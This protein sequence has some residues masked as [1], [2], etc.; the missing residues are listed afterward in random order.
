MEL[1]DDGD[2]ICLIRKMIQGRGEGT[3]CISKGEGHA[4][5]VLVRNARFGSWIVTEIMGLMRLLTLGGAG[6]GLTSLVLVVIFLGSVGRWYPNVKD[7]HR[8][9]SCHLSCCCQF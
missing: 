4:E 9:F 6:S 3:V 5:E 1:E 8:F 7:L 2:L